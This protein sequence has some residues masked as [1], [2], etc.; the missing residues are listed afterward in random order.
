MRGGG[1]ERAVSEPGEEGFAQRFFQAERFAVE[2]G[3]IP[4][5]FKDGGDAE[6]FGVEEGVGAADGGMVVGVAARGHRQAAPACVGE[7]AFILGRQGGGRV[8]DLQPVA[9]QRVE[10]GLP[11]SGAQPVVRV[12][13]DGDSAQG[14]DARDDF[15]GG[16][17]F[18]PVWQPNAEAQQVPF[19]RRNLRSRD[20]EKTVHRFAV[21]AQEAFLK[22]VAASVAGVVV[23]EREAV[24]TPLA[25][26]VNEGLRAAH[27]IPGEKGMHMGI[28]AEGHGAV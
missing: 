18:E 14:V 10:D 12:G 21:F 11:D 22:Q 9:V 2:R 5:A 26:G 8:E 23:G 15:L 4:E 19:R 27:P 1:L 28:D 3:A 24:Q 17:V 16:R 20:D 6:A 13:G 7:G 25:G